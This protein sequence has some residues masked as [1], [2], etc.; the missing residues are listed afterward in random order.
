MFGDLA[1]AG[2]QNRRLARVEA[3]EL[4]DGQVADDLRQAEVLQND[5]LRVETVAPVLRLQPVLLCEDALYQREL[6]LHVF[7]VALGVVYLNHST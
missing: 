3:H 4:R 6:V 2:G 1:N 7:V 5:E